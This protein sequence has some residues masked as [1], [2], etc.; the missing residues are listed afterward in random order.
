VSRPRYR[1]ARVGAVFRH[2]LVTARCCLSNLSGIPVRPRGFSRRLFPRRDEG[3]G[4]AKSAHAFRLSC[5]D[6]PTASDVRC[7]PHHFDLATLFSFPTQNS[8][9]TG[10]VGAGLSPWPADRP[11]RK[12]ALLPISCYETSVSTGRDPS[13]ET[14]DLLAWRS[15]SLALCGSPLSD[16]LGLVSLLQDRNKRCP[17][18]PRR[19]VGRALVPLDGN[20][21]VRQVHQR[22]GDIAERRQPPFDLGDAFV[23]LLFAPGQGVMATFNTPSR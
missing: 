5:A 17:L 7:W 21:A 8:D 10:Y 16:R 15:F 12:E 1:A 23:F 20:T 11:I 18:D 13:Y 3:G 14:L 22:T 6:L 2:G 19:E 9:A 4:G